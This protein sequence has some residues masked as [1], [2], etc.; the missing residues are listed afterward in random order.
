[1]ACGPLALRPVENQPTAHRARGRWRTWRGCLRGQRGARST[2]RRWPR[3][4]F[5]VTAPGRRLR[6][7]NFITDVF[8]F[9]GARSACAAPRREP[10]DR[11]QS[12]CALAD[13]AWSSWPTRGA[14]H[15]TPLAEV[16]F[17]RHRDKSAASVSKLRDYIRRAPCRTARARFAPWRTGRPPT[18]PARSVMAWLSSR[19]RACSADRVTSA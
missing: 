15:P 10:A 7:R 18:E 12:T 13:L 2:P 1:M 17:H 11:L 4:L 5:T 9:C 6:L 16:L 14:L 3:L 19:P 8:E